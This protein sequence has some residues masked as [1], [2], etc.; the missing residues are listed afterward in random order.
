MIYTW[1]LEVVLVRQITRLTLDLLLLVVGLL[2]RPSATTPVVRHPK[3][4]LPEVQVVVRGGGVMELGLV[5]YTATKELALKGIDRLKGL[6]VG[7]TPTGHRHGTVKVVLVV[8]V[9]RRYR[10]QVVV[11]GFLVVTPRT[12]QVPH[13]QVGVTHKVVH[14]ISCLPVRVVSR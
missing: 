7:T 9:H 8:V 5:L 12:Q 1:S 13:R 3:V 6:W 11:G 2:K 14:P 10:F 4:I